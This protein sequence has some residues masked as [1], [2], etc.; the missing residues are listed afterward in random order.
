MKPLRVTVLAP[1]PRGHSPG[2][3][4]RFEQWFDLLPADALRVK[5]CS[6]FSARDLPVLH[7]D[8]R[9][10]AKGGRLLTAFVRRI[11]DTAV[12]SRSDVVLIYCGLYPLGPPVFER[13]LQHRVPSVFD[14]DDAIYLPATGRHRRALNWLRQPGKIAEIVSLATHTTVGN[15]NLATFAGRH[16]ERVS[17]VPTTLDVDRYRPHK[18]LPGRARRFRIGWSGSFSTMAH[19]Q[20]IDGALRKVL[21][22]RR[23]ELAVSGAPDYRLPGASNIVRLQWSPA[24]EQG[25]V[26]SFDVGIMPLPD[27]EA[28]RCK[29]GFKALFYMALGVP[30]IASPVGV[31][32]DI[33]HQGVNGLLATTEAEWIGA[34]SRLIDDEGL[35]RE[36]GQA[37]RQTVVEHFSGQEWSKVFLRILEEAASGEGSRHR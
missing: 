3:R 35:R 5:F 22:D 4:F 12:S 2:Q 20:S 11:G 36:L 18:R 7:V 25:D 23:V 13:M 34:I 32:R 26:A 14:F 6:A 9:Y 1:Y 27:D 28:T 31:N 21:M 8:R 19:L 16:S 10:A 24:S 29:C 30:C 37:G 17:V 15:R 33:I